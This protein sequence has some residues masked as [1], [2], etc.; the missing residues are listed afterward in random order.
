MAVR[1][2]VVKALSVVMLLGAA[3]RTVREVRPPPRGEASSEEETKLHLRDGDVII[4]TRWSSDGDTFTAT[5]TRFDAE[6]RRTGEGI[7][8]VRRDEIVLVERS[9]NSGEAAS[10]GALAALS[11][12]TAASVA[13]SVG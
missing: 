9:V 4:A 11:L 6:R 2:S 5:G 7:F 12:A 10:P 8:T 1:S 3:C 13:G